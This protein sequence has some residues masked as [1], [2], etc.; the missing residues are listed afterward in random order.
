MADSQ[1]KVELPDGSEL[2]L[3]AGA[4][5]ADAAAAI[6]AGLARAALAIKTDGELRDLSAP[7]RGGEKV[8][9][10]TDKSPEALWLVRHDAAHV[11][12]ES[13]LELWPHAK[14]SIGPPIADG[15]YYDIDFGDGER[16]GE[17]DLERI[18]ER[19]R[20]HIAADEPFERRELPSEEA[21]EHFRAQGQDYK[22]ELISDLVADEGAETVS[23]YRNGPFEDLCRGPHA[24]STG[25]IGAFKLTSLAGAYWRGDESRQML[26]RIYGTAFLD[27]KELEAHLERV[28]EA[29]A[30][31]HR[32]LGPELNVFALRPE[33]PGMPFWL[34]DGS[35]LLELVAGE[36]REQL[37]KR[38]YEEI[39][40]PEVLDEELWHRSGHW[41]NYVENMYF[42]EAEGRRFAL[43]P[44]NC[45]GACLVFGS[46]RHSYRELPLRLAEFGKVFRNE[47]EGVLHGLLRVRAFTQ[48]D[49]HVYC[50][51]DEDQIA[52]EVIDICE[53]ID[54]LYAR[55]GFADVRVELSTRPAKSIG[56]PE[57]WE[58]AEAALKRALDQQGR[59]YQLNPGDGAFYG[60]KIDFHVT[61]AL[62]RSWQ[63]GTCQ[64]DFF[65]PER[66]GLSYTG[67]DNAEHVPVMIHRALLG[68]MERF[69]GILIE[70][71]GGRF[72][73]WLAP[74]QVLV[75]PVA[76]RHNDYAR[77]LAEKLG[78]AGLRSRVDERTESVGRKIRDA[79]ISKAPYMLVVGDRERDARTASVRHHGVGDLGAME[80]GELVERLRAEVDSA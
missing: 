1:I 63:C 23:L 47:R 6:G 26:T 76:D 57:Q 32:R 8:E 2:E 51:D 70:H 16:P 65:M 14:I 54:E 44:M 3:E 37:R 35:V 52:A 68:S 31:D 33:A 62:G 9:I 21:I 42:T 49:A 53:A 71:H 61:D 79:E 28:E 17:G 64:L 66:F 75:L 78:A 72:P 46:T 67:A 73:L 5:G 80:V 29:K 13:V 12:A 36:V 56:T 15:F 48:D 27:R 69:V 74:L 22:V 59:E 18:E 19:M 60:P 55:F 41:D 30:R 10:V 34:P 4:T 11:M 24:P 20:E 43:K 25:R 7:L 39:R 50:E 40:T 45:P 38:G 58:R 77:E